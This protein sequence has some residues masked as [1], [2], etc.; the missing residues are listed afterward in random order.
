[1]EYAIPLSV[2]A[3]FL[4]VSDDVGSVS[5]PVCEDVFQG[6]GFEWLLTDCIADRV[7]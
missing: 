5:S 3:Q 2:A 6:V 4:V 1:M 7:C